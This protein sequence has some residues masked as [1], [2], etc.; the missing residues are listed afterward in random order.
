MSNQDDARVDIALDLSSAGGRRLM[1]QPR[2]GYVAYRAVDVDTHEAVACA[3][4]KEL[5]H[6]IADGLPRQ[7]ARRNFE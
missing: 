6:K 2:Q 4:L 1:L 3:A 7:M 5:L